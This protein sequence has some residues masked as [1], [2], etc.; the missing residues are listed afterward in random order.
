VIRVHLPANLAQELGAPTTPVIEPEPDV[1]AVIARL[2]VLFP[3][4]GRRLT[5]A[6]GLLRPHLA[7]Y[8]D[9]VDTRRTDG[10]RA[11]V[12]DGA[13][14]WFLRAISGG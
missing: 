3:G 7:V 9:D 5:E 12:P 11:A 4:M 13:E 1:A 2:E 8:V 6:D 14:V 10:V